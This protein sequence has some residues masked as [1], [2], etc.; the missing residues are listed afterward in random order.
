MGTPSKFVGVNLISFFFKRLTPFLVFVGFWPAQ[1][2]IVVTHEGTDPTKLYAELADSM[3]RSLIQYLN[4]SMSVLT[5][6]NILISSLD[7]K[8]FSGISPSVRVHTGFR[9]E[10]ALTAAKI[11]AEI[12]NLMASKNSQSI[13][14]VGAE[15]FYLSL[16]LITFVPRL[17]ILLAACCLHSTGYT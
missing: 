5:D 10:H 1:N 12:K 2:T 6:V 11:L 3:K 9:D 8:L 17:D 14:L 15:G 4:T 16:G 13:T 7:N